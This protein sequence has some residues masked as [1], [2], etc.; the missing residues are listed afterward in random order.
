M[1]TDKPV[2]VRGSVERY[3]LKA[4]DES[5]FVGQK[6]NGVAQTQQQHQQQQPPAV[7]DPA[8]TLNGGDVVGRLQAAVAHS[9]PGLYKPLLVE[10]Q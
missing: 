3:L 10:A 9:L 6:I 2:A 1:L 8:I 7:L 5:G 4:R